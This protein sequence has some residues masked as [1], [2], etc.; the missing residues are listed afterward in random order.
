MNIFKEMF[1]SVAGVKHYPDFLKNKAGKVVLYVTV[2]LLLYFALANLRTIPSTA[3]MVSEVRE[4]VMMFP[5]FELHA[6]K[7]QI[8]ES[9]YYSE[10]GV[11]IMMESEFGSYLRDFSE[12][13]WRDVTSDMDLVFIADET[14]VLIKTNGEL[15]LYDYPD[16]WDLSRDWVYEK[17][18]YIYVFMVIFLLFSW[19]FSLAGYLLG[20][21]FVALV[22]MIICSFMNQK[23][24]YGQLYLL[25]LYAK[26]LPLFIKGLL[27]LIGLSFFGYSVLAFAVACLYLG[28]AI[29]H[30]DLMDKEN[31]KVD[32][33]VMFY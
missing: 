13:E 30:M 6:G 31:R 12:A 19:L 16:D 28:F 5:D 10:D 32:G 25:S 17:I 15:N 21:L 20:A 24:T 4:A 11:Q 26:T 27:K 14:T 23:L 33:P 18:N 9:F 1:F 2:L 3:N 29:H 7:L 8:E 22:G